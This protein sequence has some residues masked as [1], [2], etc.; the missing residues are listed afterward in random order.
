MSKEEMLEYFKD[1]NFMYNNPNMLDSLSRMLDEYLPGLEENHMGRNNHER[2]KP[3]LFLFIT[4][5]SCR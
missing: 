2:R 5:R 3:E 4:S 1:I